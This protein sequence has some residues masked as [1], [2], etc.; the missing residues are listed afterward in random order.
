M[1]FPALENLI[2]LLGTLPGIGHRSALRIAFYLLRSDPEQSEQLIRSIQIVREEI[3]LC[4]ECGGLTDSEICSICDNTDRS[5]ILLC[6]VEEPGDI[7]AIEKT[8]EF[9]GRYHVL[10]GALSPLDGI[11]PEQ[12]R[13]QELADRIKKNSFSELFIATNPTLEGDATARYLLDIFKDSSIRFTRI[14][15]GIP[16]GTPIEFADSSALSRSIRGRQ[17]LTD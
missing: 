11:G 2:R 8:G 16:T 13:I 14:S 3:C 9:N 5:Q 12:L 17:D 15:H 10:N 6:V 1:Y 4:R 7:Y